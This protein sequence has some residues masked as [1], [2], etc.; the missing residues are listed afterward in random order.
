MVIC[1]C[2]FQEVYPG[3]SKKP[4]VALK[5]ICQTY[6][7]GEGTLVTT[8]VIAYYQRMINTIYPFS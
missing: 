7:D 4:H 1:A 5:H 3:Y 8:P 6:K 2:V